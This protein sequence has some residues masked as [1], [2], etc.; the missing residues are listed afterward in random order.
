MFLVLPAIGENVRGED[1]GDDGEETNPVVLTLS[2]YGHFILPISL[3]SKGGP[4]YAEPVANR[5]I[6]G[7]VVGGDG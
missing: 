1:D 3:D 6:P 7:A 4:L 2:I 5:R